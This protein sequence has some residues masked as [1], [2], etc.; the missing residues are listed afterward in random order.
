MN[1]HT[2]LFSGVDNTTP[3]VARIGLAVCVV[4]YLGFGAYALV[5]NP[6]HPALDWLP[7]GTG[8]S[9]IIAAW[10]AALWAK[11]NTEP[12]PEADAEP[13]PET[14]TEPKPK[15]ETRSPNHKPK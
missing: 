9:L 11:Q 2:K 12:K 6:L 15:S 4:T 10:G 8:L 7:Y 14:D 1:W 3:D 5:S 13:K